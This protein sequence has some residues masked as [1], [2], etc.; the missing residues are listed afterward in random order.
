MMSIMAKTNNKANQQNPSFYTNYCK[1][2]TKDEDEIIINYYN[3]RAKDFL[4]NELQRPWT[5]IR[6]RAKELRS[7]APLLYR[8]HDKLFKKYLAGGF[9]TWKNY[10]FEKP[11]TPNGI[12]KILDD[13]FE[14]VLRT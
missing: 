4:I 11:K 1:S 12:P 3:T 10:I 14:K 5:T 6:R 8:G 7:Q 13:L 2:W 9:I